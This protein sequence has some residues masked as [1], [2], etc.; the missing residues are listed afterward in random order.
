M[1]QVP[2]MNQRNLVEDLIREPRKQ[3]R[4]KKSWKR[5]LGSRRLLRKM[6][7][8]EVMRLITD[9][10]PEGKKVTLQFCK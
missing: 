2:M 7:T 4:L 3:P 6:M 1:T 9:N 5:K 10:E 8:R